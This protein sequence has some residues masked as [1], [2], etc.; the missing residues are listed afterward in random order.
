MGID[1]CR[2]CTVFYRRTSEKQEPFVCRSGSNRCPTGTELNCRKCRLLHLEKI[3]QQSGAK[4]QALWFR[5][6]KQR[7][8]PVSVL[9]LVQ[10]CTSSS[11]ISHEVRARPLLSRVRAAYEKMCFARLSGELNARKDPP[12]PMQIS[13]K[14]H[15]VYPSSFTT[16]NHANRLLLTCIIE[17]G[18]SSFPEFGLLTDDQKW[19]IAVKFYFAFRMFDGFYRARTY[20]ADVPD[21]TFYSYTLWMSEDIAEHFFDDREENTG[22]VEGAKRLMISNC[23]EQVE[24]MRLLMDQVNPDEEEFLAVLVLMFWST[25]GLEAHDEITN[26]S[27]RYQQQIV[28]ELHHYSR[29]VKN[30]GNYASRFGELYMFL[31]IFEQPT[32]QVKE[33]YEVLRL[34]GVFPEKFFTYKLSKE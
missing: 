24:K 9:D 23:R 18:S 13:L 5:T 14:N 29:D 1:V 4:D 15:P 34:L 7:N 28:E 33:M 20:F 11:V 32:E 2:A 30:L 31:P 12:N 16:S 3:L 8:V 27:E 21:R 10:P 6:T 26:I 19:S 17:L 22:D 25:H